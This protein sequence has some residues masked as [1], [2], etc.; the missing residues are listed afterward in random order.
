MP[1][2]PRDHHEEVASLVPTS[3]FDSTKRRATSR[4]PQRADKC[5]GVRRLK[6]RKRIN[7]RNRFSL[8]K[9]INK[10]G[11][12]PAGLRLYISV[13]LQ[14]KTGNFKV[15]IASRPM[16][17]SVLTEEKQKNQLASTKMMKINEGQRRVAKVGGNYIPLRLLTAS[18]SA[19]TWQSTAAP[20]PF[21]AESEMSGPPATRAAAAACTQE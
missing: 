21:L 12:L 16:Q 9:K 7:L 15:A 6:K 11:Q 2:P 14:Q 3:A 4:W 10:G 5:S 8:H 13:A 18:A 17:W 19:I 1:A 20:S